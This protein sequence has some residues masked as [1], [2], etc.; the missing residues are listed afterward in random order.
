MFPVL[1]LFVLLYKKFSCRR[2]NEMFPVLILFVLLYKKFSCRR[3]NEM[4]PVLILFVL[5]YKKF[6]QSLLKTLGLFTLVKSTSYK[7]KTREES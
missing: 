4:F 6:S 1:I 2:I 5:L 3:I 7:N